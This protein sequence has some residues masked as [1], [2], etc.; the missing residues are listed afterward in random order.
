MTDLV[1]RQIKPMK[2]HN[3]L[4]FSILFLG[5]GFLSLTASCNTEG[6]NAES[7]KAESVEVT[8]PNANMEQ[9]APPAITPMDSTGSAA[10]MDTAETRPVKGVGHG[11][12]N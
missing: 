9:T 5:L 10:D 7:G 1:L 12:K 2:K 11:S 8:T 4:T 6:K 3:F